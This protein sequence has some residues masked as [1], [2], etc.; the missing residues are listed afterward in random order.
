MKKLN[1]IICGFASIFGGVSAINLSNILEKYPNTYE[2][3]AKESLEN[4]WSIIGNS[5]KGAINNYGEESK[6]K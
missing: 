3:S 6:R 2:K 4:N 1:S 5:I